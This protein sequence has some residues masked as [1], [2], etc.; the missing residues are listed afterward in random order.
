[1]E[2]VC[3]RERERERGL[4]VLFRTGPSTGLHVGHTITAVL[5]ALYCRR[6]M[7]LFTD[8]SRTNIIPSNHIRSQ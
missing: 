8:Y 6:E 7:L 1:M 4:R 5:P 3:E 2:C